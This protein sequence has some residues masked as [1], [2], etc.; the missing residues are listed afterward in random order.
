[1]VIDPSTSRT[2]G[3]YALFGMMLGSFIFGPLADKLGRKNVIMISITLFS[4]FTGL[5]AF[6]STQ[7]NLESIVL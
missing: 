7:Q 3:S 5:I 6:A 2:L 4:L 1:M